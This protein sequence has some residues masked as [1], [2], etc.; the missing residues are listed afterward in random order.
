VASRDH[1]AAK[2]DRTGLLCSRRDEGRPDDRNHDP[3]TQAGQGHLRLPK[4]RPRTLVAYG[5]D[6][7]IVPASNAQIL[8]RR[9]PHATALR[10]RDA[11]H[12]F[13]FQDPSATAKAFSAFLNS[14]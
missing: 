14:G 12:A 5:A 11:G 6:D 10:V 3:L 13:L 1:V 4:V 8:L 7:V 2:S 9:V